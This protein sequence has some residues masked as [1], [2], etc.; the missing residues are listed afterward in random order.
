MVLKPVLPEKFSVEND[1]NAGVKAGAA[2]A[3]KSALKVSGAGFSLL[4]P[5]QWYAWVLRKTEGGTNL[6]V[7]P[8]L[9]LSEPESFAVFLQPQEV[10]KPFQTVA[11]INAAFRSKPSIQVWE[12][13]IHGRKWIIREWDSKPD[14]RIKFIMKSPASKGVY[15]ATGECLKKNLANCRAAILA[16]FKSLRLN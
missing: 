11:T 9:T 5:P 10:D 4:L 12:D 16:A 8:S 6:Y 7:M 15:I 2:F 1:V 14:D 3:A 13:E